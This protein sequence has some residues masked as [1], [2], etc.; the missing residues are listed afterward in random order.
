MNVKSGASSP[1]AAI[2]LIDLLLGHG[3]RPE[4]ADLLFS[5]AHPLG[6][7]QPTEDGFAING[8]VDVSHPSVQQSWV[9]RY[10][11]AKHFFSLGL[12]EPYVNQIVDIR[13]SSLY[14]MQ[15]TME[16]ETPLS[17]AAKSQGWLLARWLLELGA[18][19]ALLDGKALKPQRFILSDFS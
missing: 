5:L 6:G 12:V 10:I 18:D 15:P 1:E 8:P 3:A 17:F 4:Y 14:D 2:E 16:P 11:V 13:I 9:R 19:P 7:Y